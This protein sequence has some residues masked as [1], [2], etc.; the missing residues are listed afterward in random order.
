MTNVKK[1]ESKVLEIL[2]S[3]YKSTINNVHRVPLTSETSDRE[4]GGIRWKALYSAGEFK[5]LKAKA[6]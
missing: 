1:P 4:G 2:K 5:S 6:F 3:K